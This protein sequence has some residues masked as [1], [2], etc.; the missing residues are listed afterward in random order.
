MPMSNVWDAAVF[1]PVLRGWA[2]LTPSLDLVPRFDPGLWPPSPFPSLSSGLREHPGHSP[3]S[4]RRSGCG[5]SRI[6]ARA[7]PLFAPTTRIPPIS[8]QLFSCEVEWA[9]SFPILCAV[10]AP[11][12]PFV[13]RELLIGSKFSSF[14]PTC[15]RWDLFGTRVLGVREI[16]AEDIL[17]IG[18]YLS[19][20][21][22]ENEASVVSHLQI[23]V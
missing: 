4:S 5:H 3:R 22:S 21:V 20:K 12:D 9:A 2:V 15:P 1:A 18:N 11:S 13:L 23:K 10:A 14:L 7:T 19:N 6:G 17:R 16:L 8:H